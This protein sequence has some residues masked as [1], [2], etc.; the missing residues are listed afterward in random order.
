MGDRAKLSPQDLVFVNAMA[1][2]VMTWSLDDEWL[3]LMAHEARAALP[4]VSREHAY[5]GP[6]ADAA[7]IMLVRAAEPG[8]VE[9]RRAI[10]RAGMNRAREALVRYFRWR[11]GEAME[12]LRAAAP[13]Q[14]GAA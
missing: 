13:V 5:L 1:S 6:I 10:Y 2:V 9:E 3:E 12:R 11:A 4:H 7:D 14:A 8:L